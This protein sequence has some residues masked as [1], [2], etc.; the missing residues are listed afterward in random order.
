MVLNLANVWRGDCYSRHH[1]PFC[2]IVCHCKY[3]VEQREVRRTGLGMCHKAVIPPEDLSQPLLYTLSNCKYVGIEIFASSFIFKSLCL[4]SL[5]C[6]VKN[7]LEKEWHK[8][9]RICALWAN[10]DNKHVI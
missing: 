4:L 2:S 6:S 9:M 8:Y 3:F 5:K 1:A 10:Q 7:S